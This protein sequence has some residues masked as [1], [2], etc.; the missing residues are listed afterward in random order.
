MTVRGTLVLV[1][2][3]SGA[4]K[5]SIIAGAAEHLAGERRIVFARRVITRPAKAG[6]ETHLAASPAEFAALRD[7]DGLML[8]WQAHGFEYGLPAARAADL[9]DG[10]CVVANVSRTVVDEARRRYPPVLVTAV[11][12]SPEIRAA[13]LASRGREQTTD[14]ETRLR[15]AEALSVE[16]DAVIAN[17]GA[18]GIAVTAFVGLLRTALR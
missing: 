18:L 3:P 13:R 1:V 5:D 2:G 10:L 4:G 15:R 7:A 16:A 14:I 6:G 9:A 17:D 8:H 11:T 12:A